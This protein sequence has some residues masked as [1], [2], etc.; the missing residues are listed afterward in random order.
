[1][2][3]RATTWAPR[4][5]A[6]RMAA[7]VSAVSPLWV[8]PITRSPGTGE[9]GAVAVLGGDLDVHRDARPVLD[10]VPADQAGVVRGAAGHD[11]DPL[12]AREGGVVEAEADQLHRAVGAQAVADRVPERRRLLVDLLE[13]EGLVAALLGGV[14]VPVDLLRRAGGELEV[15]VPD[16]VDCRPRSTTT[17]SSSI[18]MIVAGLAQEGRD[19]RGDE[20]LAVADAEHQRALAARGHQAA[21]LV[22]V[23]DDE[24]EVAA[25]AREHLAHGRGQV[26]AVLAGDQVAG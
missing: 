21:G 17:S 6:T 13:H 8:M 20:A 16:G 10:Q 18:S 23:G 3:V 26:A 15:A 1:M 2:L 7:S 22:H 14:L 11:V 25:E 4:S 19:G 5:R 9:A 12:D 24:G